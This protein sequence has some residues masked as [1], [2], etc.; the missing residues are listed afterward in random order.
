M[1]LCACGRYRSY[2]RLHYK[3]EIFSHSY[4]WST[5]VVCAIPCASWNALPKIFIIRTDII[6]LMV[7]C[8]RS[9]SFRQFLYKYVFINYQSLVASYK[10]LTTELF[11]VQLRFVF[12][13]VRLTNW[14]EQSP[15]W[16]ANWF[17]ASQEIPRIYGTR[18]FITAFTSARQPVRH[19]LGRSS[20]CH[21]P[22]SRRSIVILFSHV[23]LS[24]LTGHLPVAFPTNTLYASLLTLIRATFPGHLI[25]FYF[26]TWIIFGE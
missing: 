11:S 22:T 23:R 18:K 24:L 5:C 12:F 21:H 17:S 14:I 4:F 1:L 16:E 2:M 20:P 15:S 3:C 8:V 19:D 10:V 9:L 6:S 7:Y 26:I 25:I 13:V